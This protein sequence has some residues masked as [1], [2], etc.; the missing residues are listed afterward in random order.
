MLT[1]SWTPAAA[2]AGDDD[3]T[4]A[5][6]WM[7]VTHR[8]DA[9]VDGGGCDVAVH[10]TT[11]FWLFDDVIAGVE[12]CTAADLAVVAAAVLLSRPEVG[13]E[14]GGWR[15]LLQS[16]ADVVIVTA[17]G[18]L[19]LDELLVL[20]A[21]GGDVVVVEVLF[22]GTT[23][24]ADVAIVAALGAVTMHGQMKTNEHCSIV[25]STSTVSV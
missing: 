7:P 24:V 13:F 5:T 17:M 20:V 18:R 1:S 19:Q 22:I 6:C 16:I 10:T 11:L 23:T 3:V 21:D 12:G 15:W 9:A 25:R 8:A 2:P 4:A 14:G